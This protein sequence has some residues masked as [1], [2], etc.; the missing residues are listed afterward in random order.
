MASAKANVPGRQPR[1]SVISILPRRCASGTARFLPLEK[2]E[3]QLVLEWTWS[4]RAERCFGLDDCLVLRECWNWGA[5]RPGR[6]GT[7][8]GIA[9]RLV[10]MK[11]RDVLGSPFG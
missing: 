3:A 4:T 5:A 6:D 8:S 7:A 11:A 9:D 2:K 1:G 10:F